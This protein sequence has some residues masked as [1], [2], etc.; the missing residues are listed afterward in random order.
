MPTN[1][2]FMYTEFTS[3]RKKKH[4]FLCK[5]RY[6]SKPAEGGVISVYNK[7]LRRFQTA[8]ERVMAK[9]NTNKHNRS[10]FVTCEFYEIGR[11]IA[12]SNTE[13]LYRQCD[14]PLHNVHYSGRV[15]TV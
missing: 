14:S 5:R 9:T 7:L 10:D 3:Y 4:F 15:T 11:V 1:P 6:K 12:K 13:Y 2:V 8:I